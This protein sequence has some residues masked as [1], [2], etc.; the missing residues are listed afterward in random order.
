MSLSSDFNESIHLSFSVVGVHVE[1]QSISASPFRG[2]FVQRYI[3]I[4]SFRITENDPAT[5][6]RLS[7][8]I[9]QSLLP[10]RQHLVEIIT[11]YND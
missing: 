8:D 10:E 9:V 6:R 4:S 2:N 5:L 7:W 11:I 1:M 3:W